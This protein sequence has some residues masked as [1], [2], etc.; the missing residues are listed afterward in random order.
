MPGYMMHLCEGCYIL[1][2]LSDQSSTAT[3][4]V[5]AQAFARES[6]APDFTNNFLLGTIIPDAVSDKSLTHFRPTWQNDLITKYPDMTRLIHDHPAS[7][8][9]AADLGVLAHLYMDSLYVEEFWPRYFEF[10]DISD[11]TTC[12]SDMIDHV[13]MKH[14]SMQP[15]DSIIPIRDFFSDRYFY[16][17]YNITNPVFQ[18]DFSP[19]IPDVM[20]VPLSI[21]ECS[22]FSIARLK[23]DLSHFTRVGFSACNAQSFNAQ[24]FNVQ[25]FNAHIQNIQTRVFPYTDLKKFIINCA[26]TFF[27]LYS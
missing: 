18:S 14:S 24:P 5:I 12:V 10:E 4:S 16:G 19:V 21:T 25:S 13:R 27:D 9:T 26:Y 15:A 6:K 8:L 2:I 11:T 20:P 22:V 3:G 1:N 7:E 23:Q 17:D